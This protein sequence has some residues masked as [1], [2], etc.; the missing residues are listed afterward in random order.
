MNMW[1]FSE[2]FLEILEKEDFQVLLSSRWLGSLS[3]YLLPDGLWSRNSR[4][5]SAQSGV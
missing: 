3:E 2:D 1:G 4:N 5:G